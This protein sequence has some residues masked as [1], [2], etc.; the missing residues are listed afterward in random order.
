MKKLLFVLALL[1]ISSSTSAQVGFGVKA[2]ANYNLLTQKNTDATSGVGMH[3]GVYGRVPISELISFQ[4][5]ILFTTRGVKE[6]VDETISYTDLTGFHTQTEKGDVK[7]HINYLEVP[8][9][10]GIEVAEG[11]RIHVGPALALRAGYKVSLD[12]TSTVT[13]NGNTQQ[14]VIKADSKDDTG[15]RGFDFSALAGLNYE[16]ENG[17][18]FGARYLRSFTTLGESGG[19]YY[20][21]I[22]A[23]V[24]FT[25]GK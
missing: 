16:L 11:L 24:G 21:G 2:G 4:P 6:T 20:N 3:L 14:S 17:L 15:V 7:L 22:Y 13:T 25:F 19:A 8:L 18:N 9:L 12:Y 23:S 5:E 10:L 1:I